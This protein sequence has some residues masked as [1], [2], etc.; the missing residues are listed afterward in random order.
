MEAL[1]LTLKQV[2]EVTCGI[3]KEVDTIC[4]RHNVLYYT[5]F[6][7]AIGVV[8]HKGPIPWDYD[9]DLLVSAD[10][11]D[12]FFKLMREE[13]SDKYYLDYYDINP[14]YC[15]VF[16]RIGLKGYD[17]N[18]IHVDI[19]RIIGAPNDEAGIQKHIK[20][21]CF[22]KHLLYRKKRPIYRNIKSI[23]GKGLQRVALAAIPL[24]F[25][26]SQYNKLMHKYSVSGSQTIV[27]TDYLRIKPKVLK[28]SYFGKGVDGDY[29][30]IKVKLPEN[31]HEFLTTIYG[32]YMTPP[33]ENEREFQE[34][35]I[36]EPIK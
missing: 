33:P 20:D 22:Y 26:R 13:L 32:D 6:G 2:Q 5:A 18:E 4:R 9:M 34:Y 19:F 17:T 16:P 7:T 35:Y 10:D 25:V 14:N 27:I 29:M 8:R 3:L 24:S 36:A 30:D 1:K 11:F 21:L 12:V 28:T 31:Y 15:F 23:L